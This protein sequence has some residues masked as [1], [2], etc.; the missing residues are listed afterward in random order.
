MQE[1]ANDI[2]I[3]GIACRFPGANNHYEFWDNLKNGVN[4]IG[5]IPRDKWDVNQHFSSN[6]HEPNKMNIRSIGAIDGTNLFD[7]S[8][9]NISPREAKIMDPQQRI[10]LEETWHCIEDSG[11]SLKTLQQGVTSV[12]AG[13]ILSDYRKV[14]TESGID[15]DPYMALGTY[16]SVLAN[17]ISYMFNFKGNTLP[18]NAACASSLVAIHEAKKSLQIGE[19]DYALAGGI[20]LAL[21]PWRYLIYSKS[22]ML[23]PDGQ[24]KTFDKDANGFVPGEGVGVL[25]LQRLNDAIK[26][27]NHIYGILKGSS[28]NHVGKSLSITAPSVEA[29]KN[30]ILKSYSDA[31]IS[32]DMVSYVEAHGTGTSLGDP[33]E[34]EALTQAFREFTDQ[35]QFCHIGSV[36][37]NIGHL[38]SAAGVAGIIKVLMMMREKKIAPTLNIN[39]L[40]PIIDF[41]RSPFRVTTELA[42]WETSK[43]DIP[44]R[45]SVS[46]FGFSG[47]NSHAILE[48]YIEQ[49]YQQQEEET[50][51]LFVLSA[52]NVDSLNKQ[53]RVWRTFVESDDFKTKRLQDV[54]TTLLMGRENFAYRYGTRIRNKEE[55]VTFLQKSNQV[56]SNKN[57][58]LWSLC[59]GELQWEGYKDIQYFAEMNDVF[60]GYLNNTLILLN[61]KNFNRKKWK[62]DLIPLYSFVANYAYACTLIELG[63]SPS[64]ITSKGNGL[65]VSL[66]ISNMMK[67]IDILAVLKGQKE[68]EHIKLSRPSIPFYDS[69]NSQM[70]LP[71]YFNKTYLQLLRQEL[72]KNQDEYLKFFA[73]YIEKARLLITSQYTFKRC[74]YEWDKVIKEYYKVTAIEMLYDDTLLQSNYEEKCTEKLL[75]MIVVM[76]SLYKMS[77]KWS[78]IEKQSFYHEAFYELLNLVIDDVMEKELFLQFLTDSASK[79]Q[80]IL[81]TL[82]RKQNQMNTKHSYSYIKKQN[83]GISEIKDTY[84]WITNVIENEN[85][86]IG[87][88]TKCLEFGRKDS[89]VLQNQTTF[90]EN[91]DFKNIVLQLWLL[92][93]DVK[94]DK[95]FSE[96]S[97]SK[98]SLPVYSYSRDSFLIS[99]QQRQV[100]SDS[101]ERASL[102][103]ECVSMYH[104][105]AWQLDIN[106]NVRDYNLSKEIVLIFD[107]NTNLFEELK[108]NTSARV[109][110]VRPGTSFGKKEEF[111]YELNPEHKEDY[112]E[113]LSDLEQY[114]LLPSKIVSCWSDGSFSCEE[115]IL[116]NH[117]NKGLY[118]IF[119]LTKALLKQK[120]K[121][122][123][124]LLYLFKANQEHPQPQHA[125]LSG[126][127][128]TI[129]LENPNF[130]FKS[131][132]VTNITDSFNLCD[133]ICKEFSIEDDIS[134]EIR[135]VGDKRWSKCLKQVDIDS[136]STSS[137]H[138]KRDGAYLITGG[139]GE[140]GFI[141]AK[142]LVQ[143]AN[144]NL[145][146]TGRTPLNEKKLIKIRQLEALGAQV[147]YIQADI[148]KKEDVRKLVEQTK[149][150][151]QR[152]YGVVHAA[153]IYHSGLIL[154]KTEVEMEKVLAPKFWGTVYLDE[155]TK[156]EPLEFFIMFSS[157][158]GVVGDVGLSDYAYGN[159]FLDHYAEWRTQLRE[160]GKR[161]GKTLSISWPF[162]Q[163]GGM[164]LTDTVRKQFLIKTG[165]E[166]LP[167]IKGLEFFEKLA[168]Q[169]DISHCLVS[170]GHEDKIRAFLNQ[171]F[172]KGKIVQKHSKV[173]VNKKNLYKKTVG[174]L[175]EIIGKEIGLAVDQVNEQTTFEEYGIDSIMIHQF[176]S[177]LEKELG[178]ISKTLFFEYNCLAAL[179]NYFIENHVELLAEYFQLD[180][181]EDVSSQEEC[182]IKEFDQID[183][184]N[185]DG[186][187]DMKYKE[188]NSINIKNNDNDIAI[189][190]I[191]GQYP[192]ADNIAEYWDNLASGK[193]C[194]TEIP[195]NRW[196]YHDYYNP[197]PE[198]GNEGKIY[199]KWGGF[200]TDADKFDPL[201]FNLSP[202]EAE[203]MDPQERLFL[204]AVWSTLEDAGYAP[205]QIHKYI[206]NKEKADIGVFVGT[207]TN[208]YQ[209]LGIEA[210]S[211]GHA[212][213]PHSLPW[214]IANR[215][216]YILNFHGPSMPVDTACSS[217]LSAIHLACES[218]KNGE[219]KMAIAGGVNLLLHPAEYVFR[220]QKRM[221]SQIGRCHSF[222]DEADGYVPGEGIGAVL[223]KPISAAKADG[224]HIY[225][226]IKG[227]SI[228]H[229]GRTNGY[230]V[231]NPKAQASV[232][233]QALQK[234]KIDPRTITY[235]EAHGTGTSL[236]DPIEINGLT[237]AFGEYTQDKQYCSI[238]SVKSNI[239]HLE[240][241]AGISG[242]TKII[243]QMKNK[244]LVPSLHSKQINKNIDI[245][246]TPFYIQQ[247]LEYWK[248]P[249]IEKE[250]KVKTYPR[251][252]GIS[253]FGAGGT[254][255]HVILEEYETSLLSK[256][257]SNEQSPQIIVL[258]AKDE[259]RLKVYANALYDFLDQEMMT[260]SNEQTDEKDIIMKLQQ[261]LLTIIADIIQIKE[262]ECEST[263]LSEYF[264][265]PVDVKQ[266]AERINE[267]FNLA[268]TPS[269]F[270]EYNE[271]PDLAKYLYKEYKREISSYYEIIPMNMKQGERIDCLNLAD[272][273]Y[274][275]QIGREAM[276][277]RL[278]I[279]VSSIYE[280]KEKLLSFFKGGNSIQNL[281]TSYLT[282]D[283]AKFELFTK[284]R[285]GKNFIQIL[286]N[287]RDFNKLAQLWV[288]GVDIDWQGLYF[289]NLPKRISLPTYPFEKETYW[290]VNPEEYRKTNINE[291]KK[292]HPLIGS[293]TSTFYK[294]RF[295]TKLQGDEN[296]LKDHVVVNE[297]VLPGVVMIE[298]AR[299][300]GGISGECKV[301]KIKNVTWS[302]RIVVSDDGQE[303]NISMSPDETGASYE[304]TS[305]DEENRVIVHSEGRIEFESEN[306]S[307]FEVID[308]E[309]IKNRCFKV[310][311]KS[312]CYQQFED[313]G[314]K[315]G[316]SFRTIQSIACGK[317]EAL[318]Y[319]ILPDNLENELDSLLLNPSL[320][321][322]ALQSFIGLIDDQS[323]AGTTILPFSIGSVEL[324]S[325]LKK[326]CYSYVELQGTGFTKG[327][328]KINIK[329]VDKEGKVLVRIK[330][331]SLREFRK[332]G[333]RRGNILELF[334][335]LERGELSVHEVEL[336]A[337]GYYEE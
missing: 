166:A 153:G 177:Q 15:V 178:S 68:V 255:V 193:D 182:G 62:K 148:S 126:Y 192:G 217:S 50:E 91:F 270:S 180:Q 254:N 42:N 134:N 29:Q 295:S 66:A 63:F 26:Q 256:V 174:F 163:D 12:F 139:T 175:K 27:R 154:Q 297:K 234:A 128:R 135:Y 258:S 228:N 277:Q 196:N 249:I 226:V 23:S 263:E 209:S 87:E 34:V 120:Y 40:N 93:M 85:I 210:W 131:I 265:D 160:Q 5:E 127:F 132:Q 215:I 19:C 298:M 28:V 59:I 333:N 73:H 284:G 207:T 195:G 96:K 285:A 165:L 320:M 334:R 186:T 194:I 245:N 52:K 266:F 311:S 37:T 44:I 326:Q 104:Q 308:L 205:S 206:E 197:N 236:G 51:H 271:L 321:D 18:I 161:V 55:L 110:L 77:Q 38:E 264:I 147:L 185:R 296:Y 115:K 49:P 302:Q 121:W 117:L 84:E 282:R 243:L 138:L 16:E 142:Y 250:G 6:I 158:A 191:S 98:V 162:W 74:I 107:N 81:E 325:P 220:C 312:E 69:V 286:I 261:S 328:N 244:Q 1:N 251:R 173:S 212:L 219:S 301:R 323:L 319:L 10:F 221:L 76:H 168:F 224:D 252:A 280:L 314:L 65:W 2:A 152:I 133:L 31:Q 274:T 315:Y 214:S 240:S 229:G 111:I 67:V 223:L 322:G 304:V 230:T 89:S 144:L 78:L 35:T 83:E 14:L 283:P 155:Y 95:L 281:Y 231:P 176:N 61:D 47:V 181:E 108:A 208:S 129:R 45:A 269:V 33:I 201:F 247:D 48:E 198:R 11:I 222:G 303:I 125:A 262:I 97:F 260:V 213:I 233:K 70:I 99:A 9:F 3:V 299:A 92:G 279:V 130:E 268:I 259:N 310:K 36:K 79:E 291:V 123:I 136:R 60:K 238:G 172:E 227:T 7:N 335:K 159:S 24:C 248:Q 119:H 105:G 318:S 241:A 187:K 287:E 54:C 199:C 225:A 25:L 21:D 188:Q 151:F 94:W 288:I 332:E 100:A 237:Q 75:L 289:K 313:M 275:L 146:L 103:D 184:I 317:R 41:E 156:N 116:L 137:L 305:L 71:Y 171:S 80:E 90:V 293:N 179:T 331:F 190:G 22:R 4:S 204:Q 13:L 167:T 337:E 200:I 169:H 309:S 330:D 327:I 114:D 267:K 109:I 300:A 53:I 273:A 246:K 145:V 278:A 118:S 30:L 32:P 218:L 235:I 272:L 140:L 292:T 113:L 202:R 124:K 102:K 58:K 189:I 164:Q 257:N 316:P 72:L 8:F 307:S 112:Y 17:R 239:G 64:M 216:S 242:L 157:I 253:S 336:L 232:I 57:N 211:K 143:K 101:E 122:D 82:N 150:K 290:L 43:D 203:I 170:Y 141:T 294:Q 183:S 46:S 306:R 149:T 20:N 329:I 56:Y 324:L 88:D 106:E 276:E 86:L 39:K